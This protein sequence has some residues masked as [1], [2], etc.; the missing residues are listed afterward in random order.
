MAYSDWLAHIGTETSGRYPK[1][2]GKNPYQHE[3]GFMNR[4][5]RLRKQGLSETEIAKEMNMSIR[6]Y[7][8]KKTLE[9]NYE[10]REKVLIG[11]KMRDEGKTY[12]EI[13][14]A[15][16][17]KARTMEDWIEKDRLA[18]V[19]Q[20]D[21][22]VETL[23]RRI[24]EDGMIDVGSGAYLSLNCTEAKFNAAL[25]QLE[26]E[27]YPI[28]TGGI[29]TGEHKQTIQKVICAPGTE[30]KEIYNYDKVHNISEDGTYSTDGGLTYTK[31]KY[32]ASMDSSRL[33]I[34][35]GAE[36]SAR[37]GLIEIRPGVEDLSLNGSNYAQVRILVD[38]THYLK[39]MACYNPDLPDGVDVRFNT[40]KSTDT[41]MEK[42][43]K[44][45]DTKDPTNPFGSAIKI[46]GGQSEYI[47]SDGKTHL[48]LINKRADEGDWDEWSNKLPSQFLAKQDITLIKKQLSLTTYDVD[49]RLKDIQA[50]ENPVVRK[51]QLNEFAKQCDADAVTLKAMSLPRQRYQVI[52]PVKDIG[53]NE[54]YAPNY[55]NGEKIAL[56]RFPHTGPFEIPTLT[57]N[58]NNQEAQKLYGK[59]KDA[60]GI[61][62]KNAS[63]LSGADFDGDTVICIPSNSKNKIVSLTTS[64]ASSD[65][66]KIAEG[67]S[68]FD[69]T[70]AYGGRQDGTFQKMK[71]GQ[72][73][74]DEMGKISNLIS[75]M[76]LKGAAPDEMVRAVKHSMVVID[77]AKHELDYK[78]SE[79]DNNIKELKKT[80]QQKENGR[81]G[82]SSTLI[83]LAKHPVEVQAT[84]GEGWIYGS[85]KGETDENKIGTVVYK[86]NDKTNISAS[87]SS[88]KNADPNAKIVAINSK[89]N[90][91][92]EVPG[93]EK[94]VY[95]GKNKDGKYKVGDKVL[96]SVKEK[97]NTRSVPNMSIVDDAH[98]LS[99]GTIV[100]AAYADYANHLKAKANEARKQII[101]TE[102]QKVNAGAKQKYAEQIKTIDTAIKNWETNQPKER[103]AQRYAQSKTNEF[104]DKYPNE[105]KKE[106]S[107]R[108]D[109][110][111][112]E[113]RAKTGAKST[114]VEMTG[115]I[116]EAIQQGAVSEHK[117]NRFLNVATSESVSSFA[118]PKSYRSLSTAQENKLRAMYNSGNYTNAEIAQAIGVSVSTVLSHVKK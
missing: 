109:M 12:A 4:V 84:Q 27:G 7:K 21:A 13:E 30:H 89:N 114:K 67:L 29:T 117:L 68:G 58:N 52:L 97:K 104:K 16:G 110:Y 81:Y 83:S 11:L 18:K 31:M 61:N 102:S 72:Q 23:K 63:I 53:D 2:S 66:R 98:K 6:E 32:P 71:K 99:S 22:T 87:I 55:K 51:Q 73:Q 105:S 64:N 88:K 50:I 48:S 28:Y 78:A 111:L 65:F 94:P 46:N 44:P 90:I 59:T 25:K 43:L 74:N 45:I 70:L 39:G 101:T 93:Y 76:Y 36:G 5:S 106:V 113:G 14:E 26:E 82:G 19:K 33:S 20:V 60:I 54:V 49:S 56:V 1:G 17:V 96:A 116:W 107:K 15:T 80:Y 47:G 57:V 75:D 62:A 35:G 112:K 10:T 34:L 108:R 95:A 79:Q 24:E 103:A 91:Y 115:D 40:N 85:R 69:P 42:V 41:P 9:K 77:A 38:G 8:A 37:D 92:L 118:T 100:E 3:P 86:L